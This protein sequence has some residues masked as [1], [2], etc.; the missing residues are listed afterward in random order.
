MLSRMY[1]FS[2]RHR[3]KFVATSAV[4]GGVALLGKLAEAK[5][6]SLREEETRRLLEATM[7]GH[8]LEATAR[9][10]SVALGSLLPQLA[11]A[12]D[13]RLDAERAA[14]DIANHPEEKV[15]RWEVLKNTTVARCA[16]RV[17]CSVALALLLRVQLSVL[18][19]QMYLETVRKKKCKTVSKNVQEKYMELCQVFI[20]KGCEEVCEVILA[21]AS[22]LDSI[23]LKDK[24]SIAEVEDAFQC[25]IRSLASSLRPGKCLLRPDLV[26]CSALGEGESET[27]SAL[28]DDTADL[29][30]A[31]DFAE[32]FDRCVQHCFALLFDAVAAELANHHDKSGKNGFVSPAEVRLPFARVVPML[33]AA[34]FKSSDSVNRCVIK[35]DI[36]TKLSANVFEAYSCERDKIDGNDDNGESSFGFFQKFILNAAST[37]TFL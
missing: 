12:V 36:A 24:V 5:L 18:A 15:E 28:F 31:D 6:R 30:D 17:Y 34:A 35:S 7:R 26:D 8:Q 33:G 14:D 19:G 2:K 16:A 11:D 32:S 9:T 25:L 13:R 20:A 4:I 22:E 23:A 29:L 21:K 10:G 1:N 3:Y 37:T 27:I